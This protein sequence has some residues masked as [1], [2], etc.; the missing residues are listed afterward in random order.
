MDGT[1]ASY[2]GGGRRYRKEK[3]TFSEREK[4]KGLKG[5]K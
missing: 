2:K 1:L 3:K 5:L 4:K